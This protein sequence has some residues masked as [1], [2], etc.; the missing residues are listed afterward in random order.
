MADP[1]G[2]FVLRRIGYSIPPSCG[3]CRFGNFG[4]SDGRPH[5]ASKGIAGYGWGTCGLHQNAPD[6]HAPPGRTRPVRIWHAGTCPGF[7]LN[8]RTLSA[9]GSY[10]EFAELL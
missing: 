3:L 4:G 8:D 6:Q 5:M 2:F 7:Q 10:K 1:N 9:V